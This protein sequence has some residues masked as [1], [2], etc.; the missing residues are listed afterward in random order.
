MVESSTYMMLY[1]SIILR[2]HRC[3]FIILNVHDS[4]E[5]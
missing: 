1:V 3:D 4:V 5:Y 2:G